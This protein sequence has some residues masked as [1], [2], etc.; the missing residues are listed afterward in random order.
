LLHN[1]FYETN[2]VLVSQS[3]E[4]RLRFKTHA[5]VRLRFKT[6]ASVIIFR[7]QQFGKV[8]LLQGIFPV[9]DPEMD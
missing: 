8:Y 7:R 9:E 1:F 4:D 5:S 3:S 2:V 6:H